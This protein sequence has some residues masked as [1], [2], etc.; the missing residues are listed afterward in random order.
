[1]QLHTTL[2]HT[3]TNDTDDIYHARAIGLDDREFIMLSKK[4]GHT[5]YNIL[6]QQF[7]PVWPSGQ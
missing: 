7:S 3:H 6:T 5:V 4:G 2:S 1:M